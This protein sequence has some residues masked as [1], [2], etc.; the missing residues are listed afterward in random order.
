MVFSSLEFI[1]IFLPV[2]MAVYA[3][4]PPKYKNAVVFG[5]SVYF[6]SIGFTDVGSGNR[7]MYTVLFLLTMIV[8]FILGEFMDEFRKLKRLWLL[9]GIIFNFSWLLFF[10]Y[11]AF[12]IENINSLFGADFTVKN[13]IL[14]IGISFYTFQNMS[15]VVDVYRRDTKA[16]KSF[17]NYGAYIS[18]FPQLIAGPIVTYST[19][20]EQLRNRT[21][22]IRKVDDGLQMFTIGL[23]YKVL[24]ANQLGGLWSDL[25]MI[26]YENISTPLAWLGIIAYS[27]Q[28]Y[29]DFMGY[30][31]MAIGL[32]SI[33]G[34]TIP[35]NFDYPYL[36]L[37]MT[38][39]WRRWH[40]T[41]GSWFREY[42]YIPLGG[43]REGSSKL[44]R[45]SLIVWLFTGLWHGASWNF[46]LWGLVLFGLIMLE[47]FAIGKF[48]NKYKFIGHA[49][50]ILIIPLTWLLFAVT[51]F[52]SLG[53]YFGRLF[54]IA[55]QGD[56]I[57]NAGDYA[58]YWGI[59]GKWFIAGLLFSTRIP[60]IIYKKIKGSP[61][62]AVL[63][64]AIFWSA[65]Y[66]MYK[67]MDDPFM[68]FRF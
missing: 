44:I 8:N 56:Y 47:K 24:I 45:N 22:S 33:M 37:T 10:K 66:C 48:L 28:L 43:S 40:I 36:S 57:V 18:M 29:F 2:F 32:G 12:A 25:N 30:S 3:L 52:H 14:P 26:G 21:H 20:A 67:G 19:V 68:Y 46:V 27:F 6:Y 9:I 39:F 42:I 54:G 49:Y 34:F 5:G 13:I 31:Y 55:P 65:V 15:Y 38:E 16:E 51:D 63:L 62:C 64:L 17:I 23:G 41:L 35:K 1:F 58:K 50:M 11:S 53:V 59:Y 60:A 61:F 4:V 7:L